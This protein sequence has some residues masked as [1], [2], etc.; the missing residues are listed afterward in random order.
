MLILSLCIN[1]S[2]TAQNHDAGYFPEM[3]RGEVFMEL[4]PIYGFHVDEDYPL[5]VPTAGRRALDEAALSFSAMIYGWSFHY[6]VGER[7]RKTNENL[8]LEIGRLITG[9]DPRLKV[10]DLEIRDGA[11]HLWVN[12]N[13]DEAQQKRLQVWRT[14]TIRSAQAVGYGVSGSI[15]EFPGWLEVKKTALE[16]AAKTAL[17]TLLRAAERNRPKEVNGFI[18]LASFPRYFIKDSRWAVSARF[19]VQITEIIPFAAY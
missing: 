3:I 8:E 19:R 7:A 15:E 12:Y 5:D 2:L 16:D 14:G 6:D 4:E 9:G 11:V 13:L 18:S 10:T 17:R 1:F